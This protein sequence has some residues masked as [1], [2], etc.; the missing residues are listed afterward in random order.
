MLLCS[1]TGRWNGIA[2]ADCRQPTHCCRYYTI[3]PSY[4]RNEGLL[5]WTDTTEGLPR[6]KAAKR[7]R[8]RLLSRDHLRI[9]RRLAG[10]PLVVVQTRVYLKY[11]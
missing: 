10:F 2:L 11:E 9:Q 3:R 1:L 6:L 5:Y 7:L 4:R 8:G